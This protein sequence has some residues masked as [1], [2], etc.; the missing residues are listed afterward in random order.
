MSSSPVGPVTSPHPEGTTIK[1]LLL[2]QKSVQKELDISADV[3]KKIMAF[4]NAQAEAAGKAIELPE[5]QHKAA[6]QQLEEKN[7]KFLAD[8]LT[9]KQNTRINQLYLQ[10]TATYQLTTPEATKALNLTDDQQKKFKDLHAEYRKEMAEILFGKDTQGRAE[11][12]AKLREKARE[13]I[14]SILTDKQEAKAREIAGPPFNGEIMF[15]ENELV[16]KK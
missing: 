6:F 3:A 2:R 8:T 9:A 10:F 16:K 12:Y 13:K 15:E 4:T 5:A 1:L 7:K 14:Q 11:K